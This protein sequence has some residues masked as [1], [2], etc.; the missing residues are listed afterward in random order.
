MQTQLF[1]Q[2]EE[3]YESTGPWPH[4][5]MLRQYELILPGAADRMITMAERQMEHRHDMERN[6]VVGGTRRATG[7]LVA[8]LI[9][10]LAFGWWSYELVIHGYGVAGTI[11]GSFDLVSLVSVFVIGRNKQA[12]ERIRKTQ[13]QP[14]ELRPPK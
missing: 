13:G 10:A 3:R 14:P 5:E 6:V 1:A 9:V 11:L 4:P 7:G 2:Y 12:E 8:G